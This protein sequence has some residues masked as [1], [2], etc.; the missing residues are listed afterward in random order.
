MKNF[1]IL[2]LSGSI[3]VGVFL[4]SL[5]HFLFAEVLVLANIT[6]ADLTNWI[7]FLPYFT[8]IVIVSAIGATLWWIFRATT[9]TYISSRHALSKKLSWKLRASGLYIFDTIILAGYSIFKPQSVPV[10]IFICFS[11]FILPFDIAVL[12]WLPTAI[13]TPRTLRNIPTGAIK[14]RNLI[15]I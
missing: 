14:L 3:A 13:A 8:S 7:N 15:G 1:E 9:T 12:Y 4:I 2:W 10:E 11:I 5:Q 6:D